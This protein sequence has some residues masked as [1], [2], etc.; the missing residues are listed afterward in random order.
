MQKRYC[1]IL[2]GK[3]HIFE[4]N[5]DM[6]PSPFECGEVA[7]RLGIDFVLSDQIDVI[8]LVG[9]ESTLPQKSVTIC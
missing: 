1:L 6:S 4:A 8:E 9:S 5:P 7:A 2:N 3:G